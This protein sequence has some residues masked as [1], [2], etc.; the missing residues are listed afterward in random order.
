MTKPPTEA[1]YLASLPLET[2]INSSFEPEEVFSQKKCNLSEALALGNAGKFFK[3]LHV[4]LR[5]DNAVPTLN[6]RISHAHARHCI[7]NYLARRPKTRPLPKISSTVNGDRDVVGP[8]SLGGYD[9]FKLRM[10]VQS[11]HVPSFAF[12]PILS[13][14]PWLSRH[15]AKKGR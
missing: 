15:G 5:R 3:G 1:A 6:R 9:Q 7:V 12:D 10:F 11:L 14:S 4:A 8:H 13:L 2:H